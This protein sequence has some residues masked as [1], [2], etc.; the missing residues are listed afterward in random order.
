RDIDLQVISPVEQFGPLPEKSI[1]PSIY[2]LL[3]K[4]IEQHRST[5]VFANNRRTVE[6]I[7]AHLNDP[8]EDSQVTVDDQE[9]PLTTHVSHLPTRHSGTCPSWQRC[10][11]SAPG[12]RTGAEGRPAAGGRSNGITGVGH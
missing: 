5:I 2:R 9:E 8:E 1:W 11:R 7:T 10:P 6:R 12:H 3:H 4:Q